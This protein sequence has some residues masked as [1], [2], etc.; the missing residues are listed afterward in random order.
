MPVPAWRRDTGVVGRFDMNMIW[1]SGS[2]L[3]VSLPK[4]AESKDPQKRAVH[5]LKTTE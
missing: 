5:I 1:N 2:I 3:V 4:A